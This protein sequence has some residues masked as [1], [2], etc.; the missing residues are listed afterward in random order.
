M[1]HVAPT[2]PPVI[3]TI[4]EAVVTLGVLDLLLVEVRTSSDL[5]QLGER[6]ADLL[7]ARVMASLAG[8]DEA[9]AVE[10]SA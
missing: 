7:R 4:D 10:A 2:E 3:L 8:L 1:R 6:T 5:T 9:A